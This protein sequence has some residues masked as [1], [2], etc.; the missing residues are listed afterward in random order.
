MILD[1]LMHSFKNPVTLQ[2]YLLDCA[3]R[4]LEMKKFSHIFFRLEFQPIEKSLLYN[5]ISKTKT[6]GFQHSA[7][8][9][10]FLNYSF[11]NDELGGN[12][13]VTQNMPTPDNIITSGKLGYEMILNGDTQNKSCL[14]VEDCDIGIC[15]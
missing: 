15:C 13:K 14:F 12:F 4:K 3:I 1:E 6:I 8:S 2:A 10:N 5:T 11:L 7:L 9:K